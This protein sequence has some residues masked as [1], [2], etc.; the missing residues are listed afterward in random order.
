MSPPWKKLIPGLIGL[1][2]AGVEDRIIKAMQARVRTCEVG[3]A[4]TSLLRLGG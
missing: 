4:R 1:K 3:G 2:T